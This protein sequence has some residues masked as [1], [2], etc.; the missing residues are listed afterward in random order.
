MNVRS[1]LRFGIDLTGV[2]F[3]Q[4]LTQNVD[5][6]LI[7]RFCGASPLGFYT[8]A[9]Q[10]VMMPVA[11][12][13]TIFWDV[14]LSPLSALQNDAERYRRFFGRLLSVQSFIYLPIVVF[15]AIQAEDVI[16]L[17]LGEIS[18]SAAPIL[19]VFAI[20]GFVT[21]IVGTFPLVMVSCGKTRRYL[22]WAMINGFCM[23]MAYVGRHSVGCY[24]GCVLLYIRKLCAPYMGTSI[25]PQRFPGQCSFY[26]QERRRLR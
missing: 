5:Q 22:M 25:L 19:R 12:I 1:S 2:S 23:I 9:L 10:L 7:G 20:A 26:Y 14:G 13:Q 4:Y 24:R 11:N 15:I 16:R 18:V 21:P 3:I 17:L 8:K 6:D